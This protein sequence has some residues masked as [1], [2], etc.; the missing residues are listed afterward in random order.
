MIILIKSEKKIL[1][2][3]FL[4]C[5]WIFGISL[6][7]P[8]GPSFNQTWIPITEDFLCQIEISLMVLDKTIFK[9]RE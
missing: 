9:I 1:M 5:Q 3:I 8:R 4:I 7:S 2:E 6:L